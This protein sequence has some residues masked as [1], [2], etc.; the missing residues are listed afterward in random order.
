MKGCSHCGSPLPEGSGRCPLCGRPAGEAAPPES[1]AEPEAAAF[2]QE[3]LDRDAP[4]EPPPP[5]PGAGDAPPAPPGEGEETAGEKPAIPAPSR[6]RWSLLAA[7]AALLLVIAGALLARYWLTGRSQPIFYLSSSALYYLYNPSSAPVLLLEDVEGAGIV[8]TGDDRSAYLLARTGDVTTLYHAALSRGGA[9]VTQV[10]SGFGLSR[11]SVGAGTVRGGEDLYVPGLAVD[12]QGAVYYVNRRDGQTETFDLYRWD[13]TPGAQPQL[14]ET[15]V[16]QFHLSGDGS[17]LLVLKGGEGGGTLIRWGTGPGDTGEVLGRDVTWYTGFDGSADF[18]QLFYGEQSE[19][20]WEEVDLYGWTPEEGSTLL[21]AGI[22][23]IYGL[24]DPEDFYYTR[25]AGVAVSPSLSSLDPADSAMPPFFAQYDLYRRLDGADTLVCEDVLWADVLSSGPV[26][27]A[28]LVPDPAGREGWGMQMAAVPDGGTPAVLDQ[29]SS[30]YLWDEGDSALYVIEL[31]QTLVRYTSSGGF[32]DRTEVARD[33]YQLT[34]TEGDAILITCAGRAD[35]WLCRLE[36]DGPARV[37]GADRD[38]LSMALFADGAWLAY[39]QPDTGAGC[40]AVYRDS[41]GSSYDCGAV[42]GDVYRLSGD[43]LVL[44]APAELG[45]GTLCIQEG[46]TRTVLAEQVS[47]FY[48][49]SAQQ[50]EAECANVGY[51]S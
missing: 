26:L 14:L 11:A 45:A 8:P 16:A 5:T 2:F 40:I 43:Q 17:C 49:P 39:R 10:D 1:R 27:C 46:N 7:G 15:E 30:Y 42:E 47:D 51:T 35:D 48:I 12:R 23:G 37:E 22:T 50:P 44:L 3:I 34:R 24:Q 29:A 36:E 9:Q 38:V 33:V 31:D 28:Q 6:R 25:S 18:S 19:L 20:S 13:G 4:P 32:T 41:A 21:A